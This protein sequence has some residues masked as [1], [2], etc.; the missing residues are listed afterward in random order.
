MSTTSQLVTNIVTQVLLRLQLTISNSAIVFSKS[1]SKSDSNPDSSYK[2]PAGNLHS[3]H[4]LLPP[5]LHGSVEEEQPE[6]DILLVPGK[7]AVTLC[8]AWLVLGTRV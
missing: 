5:Y 1:A 8:A 3:L 6:D 4:S 2:V 7:Q